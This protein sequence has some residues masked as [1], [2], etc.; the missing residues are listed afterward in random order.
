ML[1]ATAA[2]H[3][4]WHSGGQCGER[5]WGGHD[6]E[7]RQCGRQPRTGRVWREGEAEAKGGAMAAAAEEE[8]QRGAGAC[9]RSSSV[10]TFSVAA[11]GR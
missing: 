7:R 4:V 6:G 3:R 5:L 11:G 1:G 9:V 2:Q 10:F 8:A